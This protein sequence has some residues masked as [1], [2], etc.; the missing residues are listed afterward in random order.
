MKKFLFLIVVLILTSCSKQYLESEMIVEVST[1]TTVT[2]VDV[3][4]IMDKARWGDGNAFL[5]LAY[6]YHDGAG[7]KRDF[8]SMMYMA[9]VAH[10]FGVIG[11]L[12]EFAKTLPPDSEYRLALKALI[13][14]TDKEFDYA[15]TLV[16]VMISKGYAE[17]YAI[18]GILSM[19]I[20]NLSE[21]RYYC[22]LAAEKG[23]TFGELLLCVKDWK[24]SVD[25]DMCRLIMLAERIPVAYIM[26]ATHYADKIKDGKNYDQLREFNYLK[27][28]DCAF[29]GRKNAQWLVNYY[30]N[31]GRRLISDEDYTRIKALAGER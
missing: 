23:S 20:E 5:Q 25:F 29:L 19:E 12:E 13:L 9:A 18:K 17:G 31:G 10:E 24:N 11:D 6:Y 26:I 8:V 22:E 3:K 28:D 27:A 30:R 15:R 7:V 1:K 21:F 16:D 4:P 2:D 14:I